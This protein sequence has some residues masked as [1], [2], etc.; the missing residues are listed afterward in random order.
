MTWVT[1]NNY[2]N[3]PAYPRFENRM[4]NMIM[5]YN[6][7][8]MFM[9]TLFRPQTYQQPRY[10]PV[11]IFQAYPQTN[12]QNS[13]QGSFPSYTQMPNFDLFEGSKIFTDN[14]LYANNTVSAVKKPIENTTEVLPSKVN[15]KGMFLKGKGKGTEYGPKFLARV[16]EIAKNVQCDYRDLL[17]VMNSESSIDATTVGKNGAS[18]LICFMPAYFNVEK[19][20]KMSP[21]QQLDLVEKTILQSKKER[22][23][24]GKVLSKENLYTLI[25]LPAFINREV[26]ATKGERGKDGELLR[27]YEGNKGLDKNKDGKITKTEMAARIDDKYVSDESFLV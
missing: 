17:A 2:I 27:H 16:K 9:N 24:S 22:G 20:R 26:L 13:C 23:F 1:V 15:K 8:Q 12:I 10:A 7:F 14:S 19:I 6:M 5:Q 4:F 18:G 11:C 3:R 25:F 21:M